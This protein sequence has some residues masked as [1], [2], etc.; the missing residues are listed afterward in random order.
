MLRVI[1][2][3]ALARG[4]AAVAAP[5]PCYDALDGAR[6]ETPCFRTL[7]NTSRGA[8]TVRD[9]AGADAATR[10]VTYAAPSSI[11][12][13]QEALM[14]TTFYLINYFTNHSLL[15]SRTV[16]VTLRPPS[17][18]HDEWVAQMALAPSKWPP[19]SEP[20][21]PLPPTALAPRGRV[22]LAALR[23]TAQQPPQPADFDALCAQLRAAVAAELLAWRVDEASPITPTHARYFGEEW[24]GPWE[25]EC[26]VGVVRA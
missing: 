6:F 15:A 13:Y 11:T 4:C 18:A 26:W 12:T 14:L 16:P 10:L 20:P 8:L 19:G 5:S 9:F 23:A 1:A 22:T 2:A 17:P 21:A 24:D 25:I 3:L 7:V